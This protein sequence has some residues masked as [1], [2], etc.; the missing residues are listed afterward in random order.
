MLGYNWQIQRLVFG[1]E[2][3]FGWTNARGV[4]TGLTRARS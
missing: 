1:L 2:G 4:G 3:D